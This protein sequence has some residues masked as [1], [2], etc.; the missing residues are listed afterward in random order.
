MDR[1][2]A[3]ERPIISII[4]PTYNVESTIGAVLESITTQTFRQYEVVIVDGVSKDGTAGIVAR[5]AAGNP[6]I[7]WMQ[8]KD[9]GIYDAMNKGVG[10]ARG[11]WLYFLGADDTL[12]NDGVLQ[13]VYDAA[14]GTAA[15]LIYGNVM[16][17][18]SNMWGNDGQLYDG[19]FNRA[20]LFRSNISHQAIFYRSR[21]FRSVG[22]FD[23]RY[24]SCADWDL[25]HRCFARLQTHYFPSTIANF[26][27]GGAST[28]LA[29]DLFLEKESVIR[30]KEYYK[31]SYFHRLFDNSSWQFWNVSN[32]LLAEKRYF[33]SFIFFIY[34]AYHSK[35][36]IG[37]L[38]NYLINLYS[39]FRKTV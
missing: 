10:L 16:I 7:R 33:R 28:Q 2:T 30:L 38:K 29:V 22:L 27:T 37:L 24:K 1:A 8:E 34:A 11:E 19:E 13:E 21:V 35:K 5:Y 25:N 6:A 9:E 17:R 14:A 36:K 26:Q 39:G 12:Y 20:K 4:I 15:D 3:A 32:D 31:L 18:G 23:L